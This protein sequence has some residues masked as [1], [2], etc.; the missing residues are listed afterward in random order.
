M[1]LRLLSLLCI[2]CL[3]AESAF[4]DPV[5]HSS[6][7]RYVYPLAE[8]D[9]V[10]TFV[11]DAPTCQNTSSPKYHYVRVGENGVTQEGLRGMLSAALTAG[12]ANLPVTIN[13]DD[14]TSGCFINRLLVV[15][16]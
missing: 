8:G 4:A 11:E 9:F 6:R 13:F 1:L 3:F 10:I 7:I 2:A 14:S 16:N 12:A 15:F 5:W